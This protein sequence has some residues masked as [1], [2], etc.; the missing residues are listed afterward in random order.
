M[1]ELMANLKF[2]NYVLCG[3]TELLS[4]NVKS[5]DETKNDY[6][7]TTELDKTITTVDMQDLI[8]EFNDSKTILIHSND[9]ADKNPQY[10]IN[11]YHDPQNTE[12]KV[13]EYA[14][15]VFRKIRKEI[16]TESKFQ[17]SFVPN[18]N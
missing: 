10:V 12:I 6:F 16:I 4:Q 3:M 2:I 13:T 5:K 9:F 1:V 18:N 11:G 7:D 15:K 17:F 14:P 8:P